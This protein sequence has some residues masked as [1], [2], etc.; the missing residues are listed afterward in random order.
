MGLIYGAGRLDDPGGLMEFAYGV[1]VKHTT[2]PSV[3]LSTLV[4]RRTEAS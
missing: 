4:M 2:Q 1:W 3:L